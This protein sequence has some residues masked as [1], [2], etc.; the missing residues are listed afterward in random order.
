LDDH[1]GL[2]L[3]ARRVLAAVLE[4]AHTRLQ[5]ASTE[6]EEERLRLTELMVWAALALFSLFVGVVVTAL[7]VVVLVWDGHRELALALL[8]AGFLGIAA[9]AAFKCASK[10]RAK[11]PLLAAT[12]AELRRDREALSGDKA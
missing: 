4:I 6:I 2:L 12:L 3:S 1:P 7:L 5:L 8:S 9:G 11:P 10:A